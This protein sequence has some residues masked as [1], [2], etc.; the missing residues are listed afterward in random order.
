MEVENDGKLIIGYY[1]FRGKA[2]ICRLLCEYLHVP[3]RDR[4]F[5]PDEWKQFGLT[6]ARDWIMKDLPF[7]V[8]GDFV[9]TGIPACGHYII[10]KAQRSDLFGRTLEDKV[11]IDSFRSKH[12]IRN[13]IL[14]IA[15]E[16]RPTNQQESKVCMYEYWKSKIEP[17]LLKYE[18]ECAPNNWYFGY[19][20]IM[21]FLIYEILFLVENMFPTHVEKLPKLFQLRE[22]VAA[23]PE[24]A[25]YEKSERAVREFC[26]IRYFSKFKESVLKKGGVCGSGMS[27]K[28]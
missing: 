18:K 20:T 10:E 17:E 16:T 22:R 1:P 27:C 4:F 3:Y 2:Q 19:P 7:I 11:K 6:E 14:G 8:D 12:D 21:D 23:I 28:M 5:T 26:P 13:A 25:A 9:V 24:I 15:C